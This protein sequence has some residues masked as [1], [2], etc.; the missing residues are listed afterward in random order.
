MILFKAPVDFYAIYEKVHRNISDNLSA[1]LDISMLL[2]SSETVLSKMFGS[3]EVPL[4]SQQCESH[5]QSIVSFLK[6]D[7]INLCLR[8]QPI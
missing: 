8:I 5:N 1:M 2:K 3:R 6:V 7:T 4:P